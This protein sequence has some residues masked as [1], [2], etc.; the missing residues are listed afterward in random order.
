MAII[1]PVPRSAPN[2][3]IH[4][5]EFFLNIAP[6]IPFSWILVLIGM[7]WSM[8]EGEMAWK[9]AEVLTDVVKRSNF[10]AF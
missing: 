2:G 8:T 3:I 4:P 7:R 5:S 9:E 1:L 10:W 6:L